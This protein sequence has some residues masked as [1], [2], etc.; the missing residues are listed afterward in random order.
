[1][2]KK[3][4]LILLILI[5]SLCLIVIPITFSKYVTKF[6]R[7]LTLNATQPEYDV[8][9]SPNKSNLP[10]SYTEVEYIE[11]DGTQ[12][13]DTGLYGHMSY[14]YEVTFKQNEIDSN[15]IWG[16]WGQTNTYLGSHLH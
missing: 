2:N 3:Y 5:I 14:K 10:S 12:Y 6:T 15:R 8:I 16:V 9:F 4:K 13:I 11:S 7:G 1:M